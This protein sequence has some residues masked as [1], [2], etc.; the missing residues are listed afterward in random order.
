MRQTTRRSKRH[1]LSKWIASVE[2]DRLPVRCSWN[3]NFLVKSDQSP[4]IH[5]LT[6]H[7]LD[8]LMA[9]VAGV[10]VGRWRILLRD[11]SQIR[12]LS[13]TYNAEMGEDV[14]LLRVR[15]LSDLFE[16]LNLYLDIFN[17][18]LGDGFTAKTE[19]HFW[20]N[21]RQDEHHWVRVLGEQVYRSVELQSRHDAQKEILQACKLPLSSLVYLFGCR[22]P[23]RKDPKSKA[24]NINMSRM[25]RFAY[26]HASISVDFGHRPVKKGESKEFKERVETALK[27]FKERF[28][29]PPP[30]LTSCG[31]TVLY[32]PPMNGAE[33]DLDN[34]VRKAIIPAVHNILSH[35]RPRQ[36]F[37]IRLKSAIRV[38][39]T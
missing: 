17:P 12:M 4:A 7:Y 37:W 29:I 2:R 23:L 15:R 36:H 3:C 32:V 31:V 35:L 14:L 26:G 1:C 33:V 22:Y 5:S 21:L 13:C 19:Q 25:L 30:L 6:K 8:L 11:D 38:I 27:E 10:D 24:L 39:Q 20:S 28:S 9:P 18:G 16:D 34:L